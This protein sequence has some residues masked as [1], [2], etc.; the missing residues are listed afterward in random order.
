MFANPA[1]RFVN[2]AI[3]RWAKGSIMAAALHKQLLIFSAVGAAFAII[4]IWNFYWPANTT[5]DITGYP[6]GR[7]FA[8]VWSA[9]QIAARVGVRDLFDL[10]TYQQGVARLFGPNVS[11]LMWSYPPTMLLLIWPFGQI[12]YWGAFAVWTLLGLLVYSAVVLAQVAPYQ[13]RAAFGFLLVAPAT[14]INV[15]VGQNGF[16]TAALMLGGISQL[17]KRPWSSG[18]LFGI[19]SAKPQLGLLIPVALLSIR[20]W[21][22]FASAAVTT[23]VMVAISLAFW[24]ISPWD[25][26]IGRLAPTTYR[27]I[28]E[29]RGSFGYMMPSVFASM[30]DV[31]ASSV[32]ANVVQVI[33]SALVV[34]TTAIYFRK[35]DDVAL[36]GLILTAGTLLTTPYSF[37][38]DLPAIT[39]AMLWLLT[40]PR[41]S[42]SG[43]EL[44]L[45]GSVW[46][47]P[48]AI[49][50]LN[51]LHIGIGAWLIA[52]V[53]A[54]AI[55][56]I[57][58]DRQN[59]QH[60]PKT[61]PSEFEQPKRFSIA[62]GRT[63]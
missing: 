63:S 43:R 12:S 57:E 59:E 17:E 27:L 51:G 36:R 7:D 8:N 26:W 35:T 47:L 38:Y 14:I 62:I 4:V 58:H 10:G 56:R 19:L 22:T 60:I 39:G 34:S 31:G 29:Y 6:L 25:D 15:I 40:S 48:M 50:V 44:T 11:P 42:P 53:Y 2:A 5:F 3:L 45:L 30:R 37:N 13:R 18:I 49:F 21:R 9:P 1:P 32:V 55:A 46:I 41:S 61:P 52:A 28:A 20:A 54:L 16:F 23:I 33:A 24:G